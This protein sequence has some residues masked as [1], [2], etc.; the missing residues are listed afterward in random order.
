MLEIPDIK[1]GYDSNESQYSL[2]EQ[3]IMQLTRAYTYMN[4][5]DSED[6]E[7]KKQLSKVNQMTL[8]VASKCRN[9]LLQMAIKKGGSVEGN[10]LKFNPE[11]VNIRNYSRV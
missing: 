3:F 2:N 5:V 6:Q 4:S 1:C 7:R 10:F 11:N 8:E 9:D